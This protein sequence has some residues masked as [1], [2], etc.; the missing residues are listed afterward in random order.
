LLKKS[1]DVGYTTWRAGVNFRLIDVDNFYSF[2][3]KEDRLVLGKNVGGVY[4]VLKS[5]VEP[6]SFDT[7]YK[8]DIIAR[9]TSIR[10]YVDDVLKVD[11]ADPD[12]VE[13]MVALATWNEAA[14]SSK[15]VWDDVLVRRM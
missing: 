3:D 1:V 15:S 11:V 7:W 6:Y 10:V 2:H 12:L 5:V 4:S 13:G 9:G 14:Y 8:W